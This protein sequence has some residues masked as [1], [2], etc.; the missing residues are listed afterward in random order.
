MDEEIDYLTHHPG[1]SCTGSRN[2][3]GSQPY[4]HFAADFSDGSPHCLCNRPTGRTFQAYR[5]TSPGHS[6][7]LSDRFDTPWPGLL[8][9]YQYDDHSAFRTRTE[10]KRFAESDQQGWKFSLDRNP[11]AYRSDGQPDPEYR[12]ADWFA[13]DQYSWQC[14]RRSPANHPGYCQWNP[15]HPAHSSDQH[16]PVGRWLT[17]QRMVAK[18]NA[19]IAAGTH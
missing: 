8:S 17:C 7:L 6:S 13:I 12:T 14:G 16:L 5:A 11:V 19:Y 10:R 4:H 9:N 15:Q 1:G 2:P 18:Q 3:L